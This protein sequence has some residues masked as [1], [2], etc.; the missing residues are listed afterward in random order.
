MDEE[1]FEEIVN[2]IDEDL[3]EHMFIWKIIYI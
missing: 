2:I 1:E 3:D